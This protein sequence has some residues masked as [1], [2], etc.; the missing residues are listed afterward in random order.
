[1]YFGDAGW[2]D[3][4]QRGYYGND[5][6]NIVDYNR[7]A[8]VAQYADAYNDGLALARNDIVGRNREVYYEKENS[9][10]SDNG[11]VSANANRFRNNGFGRRYGAG[12]YG[13]D[14]YGYGGFNRYR[15]RPYRFY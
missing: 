5:D 4:G 7:G 12:F 13:N 14:N 3:S 1:M 6:R 10:R 11:Y 15:F 8:E 2:G 9:F